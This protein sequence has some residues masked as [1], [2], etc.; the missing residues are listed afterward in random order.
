MLPDAWHLEYWQL[1][2]AEQQLLMIAVPCPTCGAL[3]G[4]GCKWS[5][6]TTP[7]DGALHAFRGEVAREAYDA[8]PHM[9]TVIQEQLRLQELAEVAERRR[10]DEVQ[11]LMEVMRTCPWCGTLYDTVEQ[12]EEHEVTC[13]S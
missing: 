7:M 6:V 9:L 4:N 2:G 13:D 10:R 5:T 1:K 3:A 12:L 11:T 8:N